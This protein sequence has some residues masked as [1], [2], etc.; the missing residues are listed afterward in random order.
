ML[1]RSGY[2]NVSFLKE[3]SESKDK[4]LANENIEYKNGDFDVLNDFLS[5]K[6]DINEHN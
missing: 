2:G 6:N 4:D 5:G 3:E 1:F